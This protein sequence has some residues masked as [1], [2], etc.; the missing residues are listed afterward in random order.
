MSLGIFDIRTCTLQQ[1]YFINVKKKEKNASCMK[2][3]V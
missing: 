2:F 1:P 3:H